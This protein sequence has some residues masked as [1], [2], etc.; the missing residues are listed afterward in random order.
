M[1]SAHGRHEARYFSQGALVTPG[2]KSRVFYLEE[3]MS[4]SDANAIDWNEI[5]VNAQWQNIDSGHGGECW[6]SWA[7]KEAAKEFFHHS[8]QSQAA[9]ERVADICSMIRPG[10][11]ALDIGAGPGNVAIPV[12]KIAA[13]L[14]AVEP[15]PGMAA[16]L[17]EQIALENMDN[18]QF[19]NKKWDD[20]DKE[21]LQPPYDLTF[22]SFSMGMID[23]KAS[24][25]KMMEVTLG[26]IAIFWH[27]G[28]QSWDQ[29][30]M[31][32][33]P[34]LHSKPYYPV[35]ESNIIFNLLYSMGI[36]PDVKVLRHTRKTM[37]DSFET[38]LE[39]Y[40]DHYD[41]KDPAQL[42]VLEEYLE[43]KLY[44]VDGKRMLVTGSTSMKISWPMAQ[45]AVT[46]IR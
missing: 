33:W 34:L 5:W 2:G 17:R 35:P 30:S 3:T 26:T 29:E 4:A 41:A 12:A 8:L 21:E 13:R 7:D 15:A 1:D 42:R 32:L 24:I 36:Y 31:E 23:L 39:T 28:I 19:I 40:A 10:G 18:I 38:A 16:V 27:A 37:Y 45:A 6:H 44:H 20:V 14:T 25:E 11:R 46:K 9:R 43:K 22:A